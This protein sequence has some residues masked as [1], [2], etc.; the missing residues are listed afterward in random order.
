[1]KNLE[2]Y[3]L[4]VSTKCKI[5]K[6]LDQSG[7]FGNPHVWCYIV[8]DWILVDGV[9]S[10]MSNVMI[11][12][13]FHSCI[14]NMNRG[15]LHTKSLSDFR[16]NKLHVNITLQ[17]RQV[18]GAFEKQT[19]GVHSLR[20]ER[21]CEEQGEGVRQNKESFHLHPSHFSPFFAH[22]RHARSLVLLLDLPNWKME[23][24]R[25]QSMLALSPVLLFK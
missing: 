6:E 21:N 20:S 9:H 22:S 23:R 3:T 14:L 19:P 17:A 4:T 5:K 10:K 11:T 1:M 15:S 25:L 24:K 8:V 13:L 16:Y 18:S 12:K 7:Y 2:I